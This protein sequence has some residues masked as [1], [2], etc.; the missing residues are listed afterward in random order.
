MNPK[1]GL[2]PLPTQPTT[3]TLETRRITTRRRS[4]S[5]LSA[6]RSSNIRRDKRVGA[7]Y[8]QRVCSEAVPCPK[9][10]KNKWRL[11]C[12][13]RHMNDY[14]VRKRLKMETLLTAFLLV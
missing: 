6:D 10:G 12:D 7:L 1:G 9:P 14:C 13:L 5:R 11:I 2:Y 8:K 4:N 3:A